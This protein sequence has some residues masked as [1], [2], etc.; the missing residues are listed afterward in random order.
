MLGLALEGGGSRGAYHIGV[1]RACTELG[2]EFDAICG[3]SI[4][5]VNAALLA[6]GDYALLVQ[7]WQTLGNGDIFD[8]DNTRYKKLFT[9]KIEAADLSYYMD[10]LGKVREGGGV[11]TSKMQALIDQTV[12][13]RKLLESPVDFG[14]VTVCISDLKPVEFFKNELPPDQLKTYIMAS[15]TF[16]GFQPTKIDDKL[17]IDG[18]LH[19]NCPMNMLAARGCTEIIAVRTYGPG[20]FRTPKN[21]G[22]KL[23]II[24]PSESLGP[25]MNFDPAASARNMEMG[26]YDALRTLRRLGGTTYCIERPAADTAFPLFCGLKAS[27]VQ[28][29]CKLCG[30]GGGM[31][32]RRALLEKLLP[33]IAGELAVP[34]TADYTTLLIAML[35]DKAARAG[36]DRFA[37]YP[38]KD[39]L[40]LAGGAKAEP[41]AKPLLIL[42]TARTRAVEAADY[43]LECLLANRAGG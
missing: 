40:P 25:I 1:Y 22:L 18:G 33:T 21:K 29:A 11:D 19:D 41:P 8:V 12:D 5:A 3:T 2:M 20:L 10:A 7:M 39:F 34:K 38:L 36:I 17:Y 16:P 4:G 28:H 42:P 13:T 30:I 9:G 15:A 43:L 31:Q 26:Y 14:L 24:S 35:E 37:V 32:H 23:T 27:Q 6:Q